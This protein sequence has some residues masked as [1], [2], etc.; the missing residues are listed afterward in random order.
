[1][2][3]THQLLCKPINVPFG[4]KSLEGHLG[5]IYEMQ[6]AVI[7]T[8]SP[9]SMENFQAQS[10]VFRTVDGK[11]WEWVLFD[12]WLV[13]LISTIVLWTGLFL[14]QVTSSSQKTAMYCF[15]RWWA[16]AL[17]HFLFSDRIFSDRIC[18]ATNSSS[19]LSL[20]AVG[21]RHSIQCPAAAG[22]NKP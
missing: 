12:S 19:C 17:L 18:L 1:M 13:E 8:V 3:I 6:V 15:M 5:E 22:V 9:H 14:G 4:M 16:N 20:L 21:F 2:F 10:S 11:K 7:T